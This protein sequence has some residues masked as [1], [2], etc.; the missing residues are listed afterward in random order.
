VNRRYFEV[1]EGA[2]LVNRPKVEG[3]ARTSKAAPA[4]APE[5]QYIPDDAPTGFIPGE[6]EPAF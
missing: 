4:P 1:H 2:L 6:D 3:A 5:V